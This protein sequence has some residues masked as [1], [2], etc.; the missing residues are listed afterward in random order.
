MYILHPPTPTH[1][2]TS[3]HPPSLP[4]TPTH[5]WASAIVFKVRALAKS[6]ILTDLQRGCREKRGRRTERR[7][8]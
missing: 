5:L 2:P 6:H 3:T 4:H 1:I 8:L 7:G